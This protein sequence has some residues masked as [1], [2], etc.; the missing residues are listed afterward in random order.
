MLYSWGKPGTNLRYFHLK[1]M[2]FNRRFHMPYLF[3]LQSKNVCVGVFDKDSIT[4]FCSPTYHLYL[5]IPFRKKYI[6]RFNSWKCCPSKYLLHVGKVASTELQIRIKTFLQRN[7]S[8]WRYLHENVTTRCACNTQKYF[9]ISIYFNDSCFSTR[10]FS[11]W[12][13]DTRFCYKQTNQKRHG[14]SLQK[15]DSF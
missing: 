13:S 8:I 3:C 1:H 14:I 2:H 15:Y 7:E 9:T 6:F 4:I 10:I 12:M 5:F 11:W